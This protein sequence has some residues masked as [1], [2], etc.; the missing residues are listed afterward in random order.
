MVKFNN[1]IDMTSMT[2]NNKYNLFVKEF[3]LIKNNNLFTACEE[4]I[5]KINSHSYSYKTDGIIFTPNNIAVGVNDIDDEPRSTRIA[6]EYSFKWKPPEFNT[7]DFLIKF[8]KDN[9]NEDVINN[10]YIDGVDLTTGIKL[11]QYKTLHLYVGFDEYKHGFLN[12][13]MNIIDGTVDNYDK[14]KGDNY[15]PAKFI[16]NN[17]SDPNAYVCNLY[18]ETEF[19]SINIC[20]LLTK[21]NE[22]IEDNTIVEFSYDSTKDGFKWVPLR[23]R[24]IKLLNIE[25]VKLWQCLSY[26][27]IKLHSIHYPITEEMLTTGKNIP[28][29]EDDDDVY[30]N[31]VIGA[32]KTRALRDFHNL[33][34]KK[35]LIN[36]VSRKND[37]LIDY[38]V[39]KGGDLS[40]WVNSKLKFV[41]GIDLSKDNIENR[42]DG[43][44]ARFLKNKRK[45][46]SELD[47]VFIMV[48]LQ[49]ILKI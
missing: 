29:P 32:S 42:I 27:G 19:T 18:I 49:K 25:M 26:C 40:K 35:T 11:N 33:Y 17:P 22:I 36:N 34:V 15:N 45:Y 4:L 2:N 10:E 46:K 13:C 8:V 6:W 30:Y 47:A 43:A 3:Y 16:P 23:V 28:Q 5:N 21:E 1:E 14:N 24:Y 7:I 20:K 31:K 12:P 9:N 37:S 44:C 39:G 38:A 41:L 48:I